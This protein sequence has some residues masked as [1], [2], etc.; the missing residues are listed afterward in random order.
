LIEERLRRSSL[1]QL[2]EDG[3]AEYYELF[4]GEPLDSREQS[5]TAAVAL[6]WL[7]AGEPWSGSMAAQDG[8]TSNRVEVV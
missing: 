3:F 2:S 7:A 4:T 5:W 6:D 1:E 8:S